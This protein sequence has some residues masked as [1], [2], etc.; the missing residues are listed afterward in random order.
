MKLLRVVPALCALILSPGTVVGCG[1]GSGDTVATV[2]GEAIEGD[3][4]DHWMAV[5]AK[6]GGRADAQVPNPRDDE[7][8][9]LRD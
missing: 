1:I 5:A 9:R 7:Y 4:F 6:S 2:D 3:T 8:E